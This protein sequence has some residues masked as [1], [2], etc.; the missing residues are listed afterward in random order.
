MKDYVNKIFIS[1]L[2][3]IIFIL[4]ISL[5]P[6][7]LVY[8]EEKQDSLPFDVNIHIPDN[9]LGDIKNYYNLQVK[10]KQNQT[11]KMDVHNKANTPIKVNVKVANAL[12]STNGGIMYVPNR[13][14]SQSKLMDTDFYMDQYVQAPSTV[15]LEG[16]QAKT[17]EVQITTPNQDGV[18][19][20]G[21]LFK[22]VQ[23]TKSQNL[24][25]DGLNFSVHNRIEYAIAIQLNINK[26]EKSVN[27]SSLK[28]NGIA[29]ESYPTQ[30]QVHALIQN[31]NANIVRNVSVYYEVLSKDN[32]LFHGNIPAFNVAPK[33]KVGL[34]I[35]WKAKEY[36]DGKYMLKVTIKENGV[37]KTFT[38]EFQ[39][40]ASNVTEYAEQTGAVKVL[41]TFSNQ[42]YM[43]VVGLVIFIISIFVWWKKRNSKQR[44][45]LRAS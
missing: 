28:L 14:V 41:P 9:Q 29:I 6:F 26:T 5:D 35:P 17:I 3:A 21:L 30:P 27:N 39:I 36:K 11:I 40:T 34:A 19:L 20:G 16:N 31:T 8:A 33:S 43:I 38:E 22:L 32:I 23:D 15:T 1:I 45:E 4:C 7:Q 2:V 13:E 10:K 42:T 37:P 24:E 25:K 12:T 44:E 18:F